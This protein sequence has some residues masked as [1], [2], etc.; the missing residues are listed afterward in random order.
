MEKH[1]RRNILKFGA[2]LLLSG[3]I[4]SCKTVEE[5]TLGSTIQ[6][7]IKKELTPTV[8]PSAVVPTTIVEPTRSIVLTATPEPATEATPTVQP[9]P[10]VEPTST[11][12]A[13]PTPETEKIL[14]LAPAVLSPELRKKYLAEGEYMG[15]EDLEGRVFVDQ[16]SGAYV[17]LAPSV[18]KSVKTLSHCEEVE[19]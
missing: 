6:T 7:P 12:E 16:K 5:N 2:P 19:R 15:D 17:M 4:S 1:A 9:S 18:F 11:P 3:I 8:I 13:S 14:D 10:I